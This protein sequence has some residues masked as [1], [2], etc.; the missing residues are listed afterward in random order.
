M[1]T[2]VLRNDPVWMII[3]AVAVIFIIVTD[4]RKLKA[5]YHMLWL[6]LIVIGIFI[7]VATLQYHGLGPIC[8]GYCP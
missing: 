5:L 2:S 4:K 8:W 7:A 1:D 6:V 3:L